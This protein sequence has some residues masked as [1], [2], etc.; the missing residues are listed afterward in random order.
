[1]KEYQVGLWDRSVEDLV[2]L[3][4]IS[5]IQVM[6]AT[7]CLIVVVKVILRAPKLSQGIKYHFKIMDCRIKLIRVRALIRTLLEMTALR[8]DLQIK[9][10][11]L[12]VASCRMRRLKHK[13]QTS[14]ALG[15][16]RLII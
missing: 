3:F 5:P 14:R 7:N 15:N 11:M 9:L 8:R 2:A 4:N 16:L 1:M 13:Q 12:R 10:L 6:L